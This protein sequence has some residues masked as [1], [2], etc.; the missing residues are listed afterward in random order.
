MSLSYSNALIVAGDKKGRRSDLFMTRLNIPECLTFLLFEIIPDDK[1]EL[2]SEST[3]NLIS[4]PIQRQ[5]K[6]EIL[7]FLQTSDE[8]LR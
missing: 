2:C 3:N 5:A 6:S 7:T 8:F 1:A 4:S